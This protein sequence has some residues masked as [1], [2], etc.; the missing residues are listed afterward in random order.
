MVK[1]SSLDDLDE[2]EIGNQINTLEKTIESEKNKAL[3][4]H[5]EEILA[6]IEDELVTRY[7]YRDGL[8]NYHIKNNNAILKSVSILNNKEYEKILK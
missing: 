7:F 4:I 5:K 2:I 1:N 3:D 6:L 8:Y